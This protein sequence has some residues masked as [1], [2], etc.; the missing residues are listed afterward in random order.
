MASPQ[1]AQEA[2]AAGIR[3]ATMIYERFLGD[4][5]PE[6][7]L[8]RPCAGANCAAW[9]TGHLILSDRR[10]HGLTGA[11]PAELPALPDGFEQR[12][13]RTD[14][15]SAATDFGDV[16]ALP[17]LFSK[18]R[19]A[20]ASAVEAVPADRLGETL[21]KPVGPTKTLIEALAFNPTHTAMHAGQLTTIRRSLGM[22]PL[23]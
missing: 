22:P 19:A 20:L 16:S 18:T 2:L 4:L 1:T 12:F 13:A 11:D 7:M 8:H 9:I 5:T 10:F 14:E 21:E 23:I 15:A 17:E 6:Q 3:G